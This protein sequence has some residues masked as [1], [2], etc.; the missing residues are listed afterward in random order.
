MKQ[1]KILKELGLSSKHI[2]NMLINGMCFKQIA[3]KYKISYNSLLNAYKVQSSYLYNKNL[4][5]DK[6]YL[7]ISN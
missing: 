4:I 5:K 3:N 6:L 1:S 2:Q 7:S